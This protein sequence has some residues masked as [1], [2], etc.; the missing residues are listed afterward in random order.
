MASLHIIRQILDLLFPPTERIKKVRKLTAKDIRR[1][2][3][4]DQ[5]PG[6][7]FIHAVA[8]YREEIIRLLV[9]AAKYDGSRQAVELMGEILYEHLL[10]VSQ[11][12]RVFAKR[13]ILVPVPLSRTKKKERGF[14]QAKRLAKVVADQDP[15]GLFVVRDLLKKIKK[16]VPQ[17]KLEKTK[18][19]KN[20][21]GAFVLKDKQA[22]ADEVVVIVDDVTTTGATFREAKRA[23]SRGNPR[24]II[25]LAFAH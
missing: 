23:L 14:N 16:T 6:D 8:G 20:L 10:G 17:S 22:I 21:A 24:Q 4:R 3:L 1:L 25:A 2:R 13:V 7:T 9:K 11:E 18:R 5:T 19:K 12:Q 15:R